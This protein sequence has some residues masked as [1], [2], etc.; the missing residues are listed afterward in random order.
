MEFLALQVRGTT[1]IDLVAGLY[2]PTSGSVKAFG[3]D[4][5]GINLQQWRSCIGYVLGDPVL[6]NETIRENIR[7]GREEITDESI[8]SLLDNCDDDLELVSLDGDGLD[9]VI[10]EGGA[11]LSGGQIRRPHCPCHR[12]ATGSGDP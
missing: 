5:T 1:I 7:I 4:L 12:D 11:N 9:T 6:F 3:Q 10:Q 2:Q 8:N